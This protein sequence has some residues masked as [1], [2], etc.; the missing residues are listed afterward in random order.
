MTP[1]QDTPLEPGEELSSPETGAS[2]DAAYM[3]VG[4][5]VNFQIVFR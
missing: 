1:D 4:L 2:E 5:D 3:A